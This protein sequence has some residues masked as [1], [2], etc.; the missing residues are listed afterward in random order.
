M[1]QLRVKDLHTGQLVWWV[2]PGFEP[3]CFVVDTVRKQY[4]A[5]LRVI[6]F[7]T[8]P[9]P[10]ESFEA[11]EGNNWKLW[12]REEIMATPFATGIAEN[13]PQVYPW[14]VTNEVPFVQVMVDLWHDEVPW[15]PITVRGEAF[16]PNTSNA[17]LFSNR[18]SAQKWSNTHVYDVSKTSLVDQS[19][20]FVEMN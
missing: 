3:D 11:A 16:D 12:S 20:E 9:T 8:K 13:I 7:E 14:Y 10:E 5:S 2:E 1:S 19:E 15:A 17:R 4:A 6:G 18:R